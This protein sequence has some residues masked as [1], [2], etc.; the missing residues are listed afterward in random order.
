[1]K[2]EEYETYDRYK[3]H[4]FKFSQEEMD[5]YV[6]AHY[7]RF[8]GDKEYEFKNGFLKGL[9]LGAAI[10]AILIAIAKIFI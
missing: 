3:R 4:K 6:K 9:A 10:A 8:C 5:A 1:M 2:K 7:C